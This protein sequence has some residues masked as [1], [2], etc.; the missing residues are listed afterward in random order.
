MS[1]AV[2]AVDIGGT[3]TAVALVD[4]AGHIIDS[5]SAAT[6]SLEGPG[7]VIDTVRRLAVALLRRADD[8]PV[9]CGVGVAT[10]GVVDAGSGVIVSSTETMA[11]WAGTHVADRIRAALGD[12]LRPGRVVH[13]Q[14]DAD[15]HAVGEHR[16]GSAANVSSALVVA[17]G[18][19]VGAGIIIDGRALRGARHVAGEIAHI[20]TPGAEHLRCPCGRTGHLEAIGSGVGLHRHYLAIGGDP[21]AS[22]ARVVV[23]RA[24][25]GDG[26][27]E[28]AIAESAVAVGRG[29]A[30]A[31]TLIDPQ[32]V[33]VT[34]GVADI[35]PRWWN[36]MI[37]SLRGELI[38]ALQDVPV[39]PGALGGHA[40]LLGAAAD[41]W[42]IVEGAAP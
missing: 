15:A 19:G 23:V 2:L 31:V 9:L 40:P 28:R 11:D 26:L 29:I 18:T 14:N 27:A 34:G 6:P 16:Y 17:V 37:D 13:V 41:V 10:A 12:L 8:S 3:K 42:Q 30:A 25:G 38:D 36:P 24:E 20:P 22:D 39:V 5:A 21:A 35:G 33:V 1:E 4:R 7:A 32:R